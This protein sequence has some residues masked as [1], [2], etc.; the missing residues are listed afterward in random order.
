[1]NEEIDTYWN[2]LDDHDRRWS[3]EEEQQ[4]RCFN[5]LDLTAYGIQKTC[6]FK[7]LN[8]S[9]FTTLKS[10]SPGPK[11]LQGTHSY[12]ILA[13]PRYYGAFNYIPV[14]QE[15]KDLRSD[16][17]I[18]DDDDEGNDEWQSDKVRIGLNLAFMP[19]EMVREIKFAGKAPS[20]NTKNNMC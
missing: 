1:M 6:D 19:E 7:M 2:S 5:K 14:A 18:D 16:F 8:D 4:F 12:D 15:G 20:Y 13:N 3:I 11:T 9:S 10:S 17:I